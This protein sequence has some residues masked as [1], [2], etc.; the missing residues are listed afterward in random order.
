M[1]FVH[2]I[3]YL[4]EVGCNRSRASQKEASRWY[5][6]ASRALAK[7]WMYWTLLEFFFFGFQVWTSWFSLPFKVWEVFFPRICPFWMHTSWQ[8]MGPEPLASFRRPPSRPKRLPGANRL[9]VLRPLQRNNH[10]NNQQWHLQKLR[11]QQNPSMTYPCSMRC[12]RYICSWHEISPGLGGCSVRR[13]TPYCPRL[14]CWAPWK[15]RL[16]VDDW[17]IGPWVVALSRPHHL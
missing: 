4:F 2:T 10:I 1:P 8:N 14:R 5:A 15:R 7:Y 11:F 3:S 12:I 16:L 17:A 6:C 13:M 9:S